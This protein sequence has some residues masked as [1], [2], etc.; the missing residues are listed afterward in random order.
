MSKKYIYGDLDVQGTLTEQGVRVGTYSKPSGGIPKT[1]LASAVQASL[2]KADS[3]QMLGNA[4]GMQG[5]NQLID[6]SKLSGSASGITCTRNTDGT[7]TINGTASARVIMDTPINLLANHHYILLGCP[8]GGSS[9]KYQFDLNAFPLVDTGEGAIGISTS[10][11]ST[12]FR[13]RIESGCTV[14]NLIFRPQVFDLTQLFDAGNE[15]NTVEEF[16]M[17]FPAN[18]YPYCQGGFGDLLWEN[19]SPASAFAEQEIGLTLSPYK[20]IEIETAMTAGSR[21]HQFTKIH[22]GD[23]NY[24]LHDLT[25]NGIFA[26]THR[27]SIFREVYLTGVG[28]LRISNAG[29]FYTNDNLVIDNSRAV[30]LRIYGIR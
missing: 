30:P 14:N 3:G 28:G 20:F 25:D 24:I 1:D 8:V 12:T 23:T 11:L 17:L 21:T 13:I 26:G 2:G 6:S 18:Y 5:W 7:L 10:N 15:P 19:A 16:R 4:I 22:V 29:Y 27:F 9:D